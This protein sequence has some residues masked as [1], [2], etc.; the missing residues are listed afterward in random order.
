[1]NQLGVSQNNII[2]SGLQT[3]AVGVAEGPSTFINIG[4]AVPSATD[5]VIK[6]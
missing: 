5:D 2:G 1:M 3:S 4:G 6:L